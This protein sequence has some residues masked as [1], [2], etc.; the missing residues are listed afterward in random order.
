MALRSARRLSCSVSKTVVINL[1]KGTVSGGFPRVTARLWTEQDSRAEQFV[2]ALAPLPALADIYRV[3]QSTYRALSDRVV[4]RQMKPAED[5]LEIEEGGITQVSQQSFE[6]HSQQFERVMNSWLASPELLEIERQLRSYL[7]LTDEIRVIFETDDDLTLRLPWHCWTFFQDYPKAEMALSQPTYKRIESRRSAYHAG[8]SRQQTRILAIVGNQKG[9]DVGLEQQTLQALPEAEVEFLIAPSREAF[10]RALWDSAGWD[11]L[12]FAGHSQTEGQTGRLYINEAPSHNSL[13]IAQLK[14][15]LKGA[16]AHGL[17]LAIFNSC[18]GIGLAQALGQLNIPQVIVMR[19][20]VPNRVAQRF[21][22]YFL[23]GLAKEKLPLYL[24]MRQARRK[25]QGL[26][27]QFPG[28]SWLPVLCQNPSTRSLA[29]AQLGGVPDCPYRGLEAFRPTDAHLFFGR[30]KA[31]SDLTTAV[32]QPFVAVTGPSGSGKSSV[33]FAGLIPKLQQQVA[34]TWQVVSCRPGTNPFD[35][36]AESLTALWMPLEKPQGEYVRLET[37]ALSVE[38]QQNAQALCHAIARHSSPNTRLLLVIDQFEELYTLCPIEDR[39]AFI[40]LLLNATQSA[41]AFTLLLTLRADFY[42]QALSD[43]RLSDALQTGGYNLGPMNAVELEAAIAQPAAQCQVKLEPGLT[44]KLVQATLGQAGR[45]P[46]L[47]FTLFELWSQQKSR[48][49]T[50]EAYRAIGGIEESVAN[51]AEAAYTELSVDEQSRVQRVFMQLIEPNEN[52]EA[53]RRLA[54]RDEIGADNWPL[55]AK[56]ASARL[57]VTNHE[58]ANEQETAEIIHEALIYNWGRLAY[59]LQIDGD[60]RRW[61]EEI[62][63]A[64]NQWEKSE[65][66]PEALLRGKRLSIAADWYESRQDELSADEAQF[67]QKSVVAN[68]SEQKRDQRRRQRVIASL[69]AGLLTALGL[70]GLT[71]YQS[72]RAAMSKV[73]AIATSSNLLFASGRKLDALMAALQAQQQFNK[74]LLGKDTD[75]KNSVASTLQQ[76]VSRVDERNRLSGHEAGALAVAFSAD[77]EMIASASEDGTIKLWKPDG[78][79]INTLEGHEGDIWGLAISPD[80]RTIASASNDKTVRL[81]QRDGTPVKTIEDHKHKATAV[82]FSQDGALIASADQSGVVKVW[83]QD[84]TFLREIDAHQ[85]KVDAIAFSPVNSLLATG[86]GDGTIKTWKLED[87]LDRTNSKISPENTFSVGDTVRGLDFSPD[88]KTIA[89]ANADYTIK[90]WKPGSS[91]HTVVFS[92]SGEDAHNNVV[93]SVAFSP[94]G[95]LIASASSDGTVKLWQPD[96]FLR[97]TFAGHENGVLDVA[98]SPDS[99]TIASA[100]YDHTIR[101]WQE[102]SSNAL[103]SVLK[104][105]K[106]GVGDIAIGSQTDT[107][108]SSSWD[109]T[110]KLWQPNGAFIDTFGA[111][112]GEIDS[113]AISPNEQTIAAG[114][115][116]GTLALWTI[117]DKTSTEFRAHNEWIKSVAFSPTDGQAIASAS[118]D[119]TIKLWRPNGSLIRKLDDHQ[120]DVRQ[121]VFSPDGQLMASASSDKTIKLWQQDGFLLKTLERHKAAVNS[122]AFSPDNDLMV[123]GS[124]DSTL[125]LWRRDGQFVKAL[126]GHVGRVIEVAFSPTGEM[127]VSTGVDGT[128]R[129]WSKQG[130]AL[131]T[132]AAHDLRPIG[133]AFDS[134]GDQLVITTASGLVTLW[135]VD[136]VLDIEEVTE[137]GC[138]WVEPYIKNNEKIYPSSKRLCSSVLRG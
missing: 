39:Q 19:E 14:E 121:V 103:L 50:H 74:I 23:A 109:G 57:I 2:G 106:A 129:L 97:A 51:Y 29:W 41:P 102:N 45:L 60:F 9:I 20:P 92:D 55:V 30:E 27:N 6:E 25:L 22:Q 44:D 24:A 12:F 63:R 69:S 68:E 96:G 67:I 80:G 89:S 13:T 116:D 127:I 123:S 31:I 136:A 26:E 36:L 82:A 114:H 71:W 126:E 128:I 135:D 83:Q 125:M 42:A 46:L 118:S 70:S 138:A 110:L 33:V 37:L 95:Q 43:R 3:W 18:D 108:V 72:Q 48:Q 66:E 1:G 111:G 53:T 94:N 7:S 47:E 90:L 101:L 130:D 54:T 28:A 88:G 59:W 17:Q 21:L 73:R 32:K 56:L 5:E 8:Q 86:S 15:G 100:S 117:A 122:V 120:S 75:I 107:I 58:A 134:S 132:L 76:A 133:I 91:E 64:K 105:H 49:L 137:L 104:G 40:A 98:F 79:L 35:V 113:V 77:G 124:D 65:R 115:E 84:G 81:W 93:Y 62:R 119:G 78:E 10:D 99:K 85:D 112:E 131:E 34:P 52:S 87:V 38:C 61:Q 16:I 11:I 4:L